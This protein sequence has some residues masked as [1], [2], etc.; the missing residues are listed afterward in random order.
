MTDAG[1]KSKN[2]SQII[3]D[4][5]NEVLTRNIM[6]CKTNMVASQR[7]VV[8]G[9]YITVDNVKM[10]QAYQL[11]AS[12][13]QDAQNVAKVQTEVENA[14]KQAAESQGI[15]LLSA[16][17]GSQ[18][19]VDSRIRNSV[20]TAI[21]TETIQDVVQ[22][23]N[24]E[25]VLNIRGENAIVKDVTME[26]LGDIVFKNTQAITNDIEALTALKT[27]AEQTTETTTTS[28]FQFLV[29][30]VSSV[31]GMLSNPMILLMLLVGVGVVIY[32][33]SMRAPSKQTYVGDPAMA[34]AMGLT[35]S[36][37]GGRSHKKSIKDIARE[38]DIEEDEDI[39]MKDTTEERDEPE[40]ADDKSDES[41]SDESETSSSEEEEE[42]EEES[43][44]VKT[45]STSK[46]KSSPIADDEADMDAMMEE[47]QEDEDEVDG[48]GD[49]NR[50]HKAL[51][52]SIKRK[53]KG[54]DEYGIDETFM[55]DDDDSPKKETKEE[56][57]V[58]KKKEV[59][60]ER[61]VEKKELPVA[62]K[63][64][65]IVKAPTKIME[66]T[67]PKKIDMSPPPEDDNPLPFANEEIPAPKKSKR[68]NNINIPKAKAVQQRRKSLV[69]DKRAQPSKTKRR[70]SS[71][72]SVKLDDANITIRKK[73]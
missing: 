35:E 25:Q 1:P 28:P 42:P 5:V 66:A 36:M 21:N 47:I 45:S 58:E 6:N 19:E 4:T 69:S 51:S 71:D 63:A 59:K 73:H 24:M 43:E 55:Q 9:S 33:Y 65:E 49:M 10:H 37:F 15:A 46:S 64:E 57:K 48:G 13:F 31:T 3:N 34:A 7:L 56:E 29:D 22:N 67:I 50:V 60:E 52:K 70:M 8:E 44:T 12:C 38:P 72:D 27:E 62:P 16:L 54:A 26:Q 20:K 2:T 68:K 18:A 30:I 23:I 11:D 53:T 39:D 14:I 40:D 61:K 32:F 41:E 17:G